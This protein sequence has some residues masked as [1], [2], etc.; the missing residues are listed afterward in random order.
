MHSILAGYGRLG[1]ASGPIKGLTDHHLY[2]G[3]S[4]ETQCIR[5]RPTRP[6]TRKIEGTLFHGFRYRK[7]KDGADQS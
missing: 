7:S 1:Q 2:W 6:R 5:K 3:R 4:P